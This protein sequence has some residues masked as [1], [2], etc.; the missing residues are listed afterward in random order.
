MAFENDSQKECNI[1]E[2]TTPTGAAQNQNYKIV[3]AVPIFKNTQLVIAV[4][5]EG[6][7]HN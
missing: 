7:R 2:Q 5:E 4:E 6:K 1:R 3:C